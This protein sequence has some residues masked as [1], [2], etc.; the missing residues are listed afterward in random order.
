M[1][2]K[3]Q[4]NKYAK[5]T[6]IIYCRVST[7]KQAEGQSVSLEAQEMMS[8][9]W[10]HSK[11][12]RVKKVCKE[13]KSAYNSSLKSLKDIC[14]STKNTHILLYDVSRFC[15]NVSN[16]IIMLNLALSKN[17]TLVFVFDKLT[18]NSK[19][20]NQKLDQFTK[21]LT[22]A[23]SESKKI[24][25]RLKTVKQYLNEQGKYSGGYIPYGYSVIKSNDDINN[26]LVE[27]VKEKNIIAF[28]TLCRTNN[29][30][31]KQLNK[32]MRVISPQNPYIEIN[33]YDKDQETVIENITTAL[34]YKE[35]A[36]L[37]N[38]YGIHKRGR[39]WSS[40]MIKSIIVNTE[41]NFKMTKLQIAPPPSPSSTDDSF[42]LLSDSDYSEEELE[43]QQQPF[44]QQQQPFQQQHQPFQPQQQP[45]QPQQQQP[46]PV[47][48]QPYPV[49]QQPYP[50][51]QQPYPVQQQPY[52]VQSNVWFPNM[53]TFPMFTYPHGL[54][55]KL[56]HKSQKK[57]T[58][59]VDK[60]KEI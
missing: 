31:R 12:L 48:Q 56:P 42:V 43:Q 3:S 46:Y 19:N 30:S 57:L 39:R 60:K 59:K 50:V 32:L 40:P 4:I 16:G 8:K 10:A 2:A 55:Q 25:D 29:I 23:E 38:D 36:S 54:P 45:F 28:V 11:K 51:Q 5:Q 52:P 9:K 41:I 53:F 34:M 20:K 22:Q 44:Q 17:N 27:D 26:T 14:T 58:K 7:S 1:A 37:L 33:C 15:R 24:G 18:I 49:Q 21:L 35:I 13:V 47:Q 6:C